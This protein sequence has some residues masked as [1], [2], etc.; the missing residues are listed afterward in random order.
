MKNTP[1]SI[2][3]ALSSSVLEP[4]LIL[5]MEFSDGTVSL[6]NLPYDVVVDSVT[7]T[8]DGGLTELAPPQLTNVADREIYKIR[9]IDFNDEYKTY[10]DGN[11]IGTDVT[12]KLGI[13]GNTTDLDVLYKGR[14]D[15]VSIQTDVSEGTKEAVIECSSPFG[16]LD[17]TNERLSDH[18]T[19]TGIDSSDTCFKNIY[20]NTDSIQI[21]WGKKP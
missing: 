17:R 8:S 20:K 4:Y 14:I 15:S 12:V 1:S 2:I 16:A 5:D 3:T 13:T 10:F 18:Q 11:V 7:Y 9:L 21:R 6:T 19:Q